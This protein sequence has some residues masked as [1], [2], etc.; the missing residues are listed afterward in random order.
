MP[1]Y[2]SLIILL[3]ITAVA[4]FGFILGGSPAAVRKERFDQMRIQ[5]LQSLQWQLVEYYRMKNNTL[6][7]D[8]S[9]LST[10]TIPEFTLPVDPETKEP[11]GYE[12]VSSTSFRLC[13]N[14]FGV[15]DGKEFLFSYPTGN[16]TNETW[17]H[18]S[19]YYCFDRTI[20][21]DYIES[22]VPKF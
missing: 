15:A 5:H 4:L 16:F 22:N 13:A 3:I 21:P 19:G 17:T 7:T 2:F 9:F 10:D 6:P 18:P 11:Y 1:R 8:L 14:F 20:D 12:N